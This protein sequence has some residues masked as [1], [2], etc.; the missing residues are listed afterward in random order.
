M[1]EVDEKIETPY[2]VIEFDVIGVFSSRKAKL[3]LQNPRINQNMKHLQHLKTSW[4]LHCYS[5]KI[6][7]YRTK[8]LFN[9]RYFHVQLRW[10]YKYHI[11]NSLLYS[12]KDCTLRSWT[13]ATKLEVSNEREQCVGSFWIHTRKYQTEVLNVFWQPSRIWTKS[14]NQKKS[15]NTPQLSQ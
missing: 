11:W 15:Q 12:Q 7:W 3:A 4:K 2:D 1:L 9:S 13:C 8:S 5:G 10:R 14:G 6:D